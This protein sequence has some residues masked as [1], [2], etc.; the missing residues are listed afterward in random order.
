MESSHTETLFDMEFKPNNKNVFASS[1]FD[2][3]I[4]LWDMI[5]QKCTDILA[6]ENM[7]TKNVIYSI[8]WSP[9][10]K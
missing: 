6:K 7:D 9:K 4:R 5:T 3:T 8:S 10:R 1:S 2:G